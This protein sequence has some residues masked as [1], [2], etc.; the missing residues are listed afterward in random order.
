[1]HDMEIAYSTDPIAAAALHLARNIKSHLEAGEHVLW[2]LSGGSG[3]GVVLETAH[4][5]ADTNLVNLSV[6]LSDER[7]GHI[8]HTN[9]NWQQLFDGGL[10]LPGA[11]LYRPLTDEDRIATTRKFSAWIQH[12]MSTADYSIGLF[13][14]GN[15]GHTAGI[16]P[17]SSA[18]NTTSWATE[19]T[20]DDFERV[21]ITTHAIS[22]LDEAIIQ[23][24]GADKIPTLKQLLYQNVAVNEQ[25]AQVL[26]SIPKCTL[27]TNNGEL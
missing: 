25:P 18:I 12:Q 21:T 16:K 15:D 13:G 23:A 3:I 20:A 26:K 17:H 4:I 10:Q 7:Y 9:E 14:I 24:S 11:T 2:L 5:L 6:T 19:Y 22:Q 1:M 8:G 27:Y